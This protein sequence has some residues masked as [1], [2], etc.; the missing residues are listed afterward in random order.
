MRIEPEPAHT[1]MLLLLREVGRN[2]TSLFSEK[3]IIYKK[4][5][6]ENVVY[7]SRALKCVLNPLTGVVFNIFFIVWLIPL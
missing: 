7:S 5:L 1:G 3:T 4:R 6:V 2:V